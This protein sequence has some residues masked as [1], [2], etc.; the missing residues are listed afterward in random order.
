MS[1][2]YEE[3]IATLTAHGVRSLSIGVHAVTVDHAL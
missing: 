1:Q 3:F 2:D